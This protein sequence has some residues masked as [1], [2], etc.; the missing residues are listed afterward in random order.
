MRSANN[1]SVFHGDKPF[2]VDDAVPVG[3][4]GQIRGCIRSSGVCEHVY[5]DEKWWYVFR[6]NERCVLIFRGRTCV[7]WRQFALWYVLA[8]TVL[9]NVLTVVGMAK[10]S[11][12]CLGEAHGGFAS[13]GSDIS[14]FSH[15]VLWISLQF[16]VC[17]L[18][19]K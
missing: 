19:S 18:T 1:M 8:E 14:G 10:A 5:W 2:A 9:R 3:W 7:S 12:D 17:L 11:A 16:S 15:M 6:S 13:D 4:V